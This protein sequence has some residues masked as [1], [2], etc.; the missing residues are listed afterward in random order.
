MQENHYFST[1]K[2]FEP[3]KMIMS[4][5]T[6]QLEAET[7]LKY[8]CELVGLFILHEAKSRFV[9]ENIGLYRV[10]G[11][12]SIHNYSG[13][14]ADRARKDILQLFKSHGLNITVETNLT[15]C[16]FFL[17]FYYYCLL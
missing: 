15:S 1:K 14:M 11:L 5:L 12:S 9:K 6:L 10:D 3:R 4:Y 13:P 17:R 16:R 8:A 2:K 7:E